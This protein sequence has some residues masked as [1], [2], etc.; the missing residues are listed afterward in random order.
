MF[1]NIKKCIKRMKRIWND[2]LHFYS[3]CHVI[4]RFL[5]QYVL[6]FF[7]TLQYFREILLKLKTFYIFS[8]LHRQ[9]PQ[10]SRTRTAPTKRMK[11]IRVKNPGRL[12]PGSSRGSRMR[13]QMRKRRKNIWEG[14]KKNSKKSNPRDVIFIEHFQKNNYFSPYWKC[15]ELKLD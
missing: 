14:K 5:V 15:K 8:D 3:S 1:G 11:T 2:S 4:F 12:S 7:V 6:G 10:F 13:K 9:P